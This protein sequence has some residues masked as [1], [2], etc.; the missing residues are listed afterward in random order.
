MNIYTKSGDKGSTSLYSGERVPKYSLRVEAYGTIDELDAALGMARSLCKK[1]AVVE[2]VL[3]VQKLLGRI[4]GEIAT[5][6]NIKAPIT[7]VNVQHIEQ[8]IDSFS[9]S[10]APLQRFLISGNSP[11]SAALHVSRTIARRAERLLWQLSQE[12]QVNEKVLIILN[13]LS[14]YCF[15]LS[16]REDEI[17]S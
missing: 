7:D 12:E 9:V 3:E 13:R 8:R 2:A 11:G 6:G 14:D 15:V 17:Q 1:T 5:L 10:L 16:R 4:M